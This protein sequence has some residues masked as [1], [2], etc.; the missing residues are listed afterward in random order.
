MNWCITLIT[1]IL[2]NPVWTTVIW[3]NDY[4]RNYDEIPTNV[5]SY[6][7][8]PNND[9]KNI[10]NVTGTESMKHFQHIQA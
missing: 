1:A 4:E 3:V 7:M 2:A 6:N 8:K 10:T 5:K 9:D